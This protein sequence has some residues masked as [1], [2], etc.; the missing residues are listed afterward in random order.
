MIVELKNDQK[1]PAEKPDTAK[2]IYTIYDDEDEDKQVKEESKSEE[3]GE[4]KLSRELRRLHT[5]YNPT[6]EVIKGEPSNTPVRDGNVVVT[7]N[8]T[9]V[10]IEVPISVKAEYIE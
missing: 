1:G 2:N 6:E 5:S 8:V 4:S 10:P 9:P 7:G 3:Q